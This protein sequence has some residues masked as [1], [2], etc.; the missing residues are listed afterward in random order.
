[1]NTTGKIGID[2]RKIADLNAGEFISLMEQRLAPSIEAAI[3]KAI[4]QRD[5][6]EDIVWNTDQACEFLGIERRTYYRKVATGQIEA[7]PGGSRTTKAACRKYLKSSGIS[8]RKLRVENPVRKKQD[9]GRKK[10]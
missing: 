10:V 9:R 8:L 4:P 7:T 3:R 6:E 2:T 5:P 1:M